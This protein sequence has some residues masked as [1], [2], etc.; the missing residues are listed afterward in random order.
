MNNNRDLLKGVLS[1]ST[2]A[3]K[4]LKQRANIN[5]PVLEKYNINPETLVIFFEEREGKTSYMDKDNKKR[6]IS[7][8]EKELIEKSLNVSENGTGI[9]SILEIGLSDMVSDKIE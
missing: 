4:E 5:Y 1:G 2:D 3:I 9:I 6:F 8:S 7:R